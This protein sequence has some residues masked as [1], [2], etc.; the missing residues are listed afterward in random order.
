MIHIDKMVVFDIKIKISII[1][2]KAIKK[3]NLPEFLEFL[4]TGKLFLFFLTKTIK[5]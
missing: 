2:R 5:I 3:H 4:F 1:W